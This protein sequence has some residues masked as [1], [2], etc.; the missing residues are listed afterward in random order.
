MKKITLAA[1]ALVLSAGAAF[2]ENPDFGTSAALNLNDATTP[3]PAQTID[4]T[5]PASI[6]K[7]TVGQTNPAAN[8]FGDG[9][10]ANQR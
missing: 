1:T 2:A 6:R 4:R 3:A 7:P 9:S 8:R 5:A 10:P